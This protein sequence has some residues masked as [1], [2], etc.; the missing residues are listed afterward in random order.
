MSSDSTAMPQRP[1]L[2]ARRETT[3]LLLA[4]VGAGVDA[5]V[6]VTFGVLTAAQT[7]NTVLLGVALGQGRWG[8]GLAAGMS[9]C[10]YVV[11][12]GIGELIVD[13]G[14]GRAMRGAA[15]RIARALIIE[16]LLLIVVLVTWR[17]AGEDIGP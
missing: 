12:S 5:V 3:I 11:G 4:A 2:L 15:P 16:L 6:L 1:A 13:A 10:G 14:G 7:G 8:A 9:V 17:L